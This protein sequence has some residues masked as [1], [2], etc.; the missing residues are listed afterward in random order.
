MLTMLISTVEAALKEIEVSFDCI[1]TNFT[2]HI[3]LGAMIYG[4]MVS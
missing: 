4:L 1:C 3:F 2:A